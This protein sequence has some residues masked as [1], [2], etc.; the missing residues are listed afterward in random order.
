M[1]GEW[2]YQR[3][4][5]QGRPQDLLKVIRVIGAGLSNTEI[6]EHLCN[7][8][9]ISVATAKTHVGHLFTKLNARDRT[10]W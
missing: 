9:Y 1:K 10:H 7:S 6:G 3:L 8:A 4:P 5:A 2:W